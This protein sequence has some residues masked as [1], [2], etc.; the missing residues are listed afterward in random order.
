MNDRSSLKLIS[1][2]INYRCYIRGENISFNLN[3]TLY[4]THQVHEKKK[5]KSVIK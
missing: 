1:S 2:A 4:R 3:Y 5:K